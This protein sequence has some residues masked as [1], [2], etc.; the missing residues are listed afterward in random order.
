ME[1]PDKL[2]VKAALPGIK[3]D[4][5]DVSI[6]GNTLTIAGEFKSEEGRK[7][8][9]YHRRELRIGTFERSLTLPE[10]FQADK[11]EAVFEHGMLTLKIPKATQAQVK[12]IKVQPRVMEPTTGSI[13]R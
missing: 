12:H 3:P 2:V 10:R 11:A 5:V 13:K 4:D 8:T 6:D 7:D 1:T 9:E